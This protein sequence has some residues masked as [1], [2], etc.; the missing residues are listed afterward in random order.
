MG[1]FCIG[2]AMSDMCGMSRCMHW[3]LDADRATGEAHVLPQACT[4]MHA[5][6]PEITAF[7][8]GA[9][10]IRTKHETNCLRRV[11]MAC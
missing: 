5:L 9:R 1:D 4:D 7:I 10:P 6:E 3:L 8:V 11:T 2:V